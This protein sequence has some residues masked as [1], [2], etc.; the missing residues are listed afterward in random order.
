[1]YITQP[2]AWS[3]HELLCIGESVLVGVHHPDV[4]LELH[5]YLLADVNVVL[6]LP[7]DEVITARV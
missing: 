7:G 4:L 3:V 5:E 6:L 2:A 1:M